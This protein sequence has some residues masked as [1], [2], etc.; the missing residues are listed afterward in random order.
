MDSDNVSEILRIIIRNHSAEERYFDLLENPQLWLDFI[1]FCDD[2]DLQERLL[3]TEDM[4]T[5]TAYMLSSTT[6]LERDMHRFGGLNQKA[7]K[8][9]L[10]LFSIHGNLTVIEPLD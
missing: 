10:H 4:L 5:L 6:V 2:A 7:H 1:A 8:E 9:F 3:I